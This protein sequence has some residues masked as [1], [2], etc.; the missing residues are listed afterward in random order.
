[1]TVAEPPVLPST[2]SVADH[3]GSGATRHRPVC[4]CRVLMRLF[5]PEAPATQPT[6]FFLTNDWYQSSTRLG[7]VAASPDWM[8]F[9]SRSATCL[10]LPFEK[11]TPTVCLPS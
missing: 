7:S 4:V 8:S 3:C 1:M 10:T 5:W 2:L 6:Y 9:V 11:S